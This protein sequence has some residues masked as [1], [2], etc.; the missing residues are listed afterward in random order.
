MLNWDAGYR[1]FLPDMSVSEA[2]IS[3]SNSSET[4]G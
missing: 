1:L 2:L 3:V 4:W